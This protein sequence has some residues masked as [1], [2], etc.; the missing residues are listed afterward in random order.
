LFQDDWVWDET[1]AQE[2]SAAAANLHQ[3]THESAEVQVNE[4][5]SLAEKQRAADELDAAER[6]Y[7]ASRQKLERAQASRQTTAVV[8][9]WLG[10]ALLIVGLLRYSAVREKT[11][12]R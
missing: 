7:E 9:R 12:R 3:L 5:I 6:R 11:R 1:Q 8:L 2:H 4:T 10:V